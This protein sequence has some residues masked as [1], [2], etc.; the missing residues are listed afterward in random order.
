MRRLGLS[1]NV[2]LSV[3]C[4]TVAGEAKADEEG[5]TVFLCLSNSAGWTVIAECVPRVRCALKA[6]AKGRLP[7]CT[8][9][10]GGGSDAQLVWIAETSP[11]R[12][13]STALRVVRALEFRDAAGIL[14]RVVF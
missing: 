11:T 5:C 6:M 13:N 9:S 1:R 3:L 8:F 10:G 7:Q 12:D 4:L 14:R 2:C